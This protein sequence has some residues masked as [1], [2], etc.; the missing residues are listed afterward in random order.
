MN[1]IIQYF[2]TLEQRL[3]A[4]ESDNAALK[5]KVASFKTKTAALEEEL[6]ALQDALSTLKQN[7]AQNSN[8]DE[9]EIEVELIMPEDEPAEPEVPVTPEALSEPI[10]EDPE[11]PQETPVESPKEDETPDPQ[12]QRRGITNTG[13]TAAPVDDIKK[14]ISLGDRFLFQRELFNQNGELMQKTLEDLNRCNSL[15]EAHA[16]IDKHFKWDKDSPT[17]SL[18]ETILNRRFN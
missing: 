8:D 6:A 10:K 9:P 13:I 16:Y 17:Y 2:N 12:P 5:E 1:E 18:F 4:L 7:P 15:D 3:A 14:A 11:V